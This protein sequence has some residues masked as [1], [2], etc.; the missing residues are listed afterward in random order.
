MTQTN[1]LIEY[2]FHLNSVIYMLTYSGLLPHIDIQFQIFPRIIFKSMVKKGD[3]IR[4]LY[5]F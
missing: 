2:L 5:G 4:D 1:W 3:I